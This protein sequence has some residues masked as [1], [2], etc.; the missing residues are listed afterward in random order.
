ME[1]FFSTLE[2]D[3]FLGKPCEKHELANKINEILNMRKTNEEKKERA[4]KQIF[5][6]EDD[7][8]TSNALKKT[9]EAAGYI[10]EIGVNVLR[11]QE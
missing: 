7:F 5:L 1:D 4:Q 8:A 2:V 6:A 9:F 11:L 10:F 3:G